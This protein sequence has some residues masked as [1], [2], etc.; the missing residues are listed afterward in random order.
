MDDQQAPDDSQG[1]YQEDRGFAFL[2]Q[3]FQI[4]SGPMTAYF[5]SDP[6]F[7]DPKG[8]DSKGDGSI[9]KPW[10]TMS[11][12]IRQVEKIGTTRSEIVCFYNEEE[13]HGQTSIPKPPP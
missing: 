1:C 5:V 7:G 12:A 9:E 2:A 13:T 11:H 6:E 4:G 10:A 8:N 3:V